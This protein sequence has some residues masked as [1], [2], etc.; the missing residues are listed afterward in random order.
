MEADAADRRHTWW[1]DPE[2]HRPRLRELPAEPAA[3]AD[4]IEEFVIHHAVARL[5]GFGV[6]VAAERDRELRRAS[7]LLDEALCRDSRPLTEHRAIA[8]YVYVTC[9]DFA[10]LAASAL[11]E[12][13]VPARLRAGF[14]SYFRPGYWEDHWV[15]EHRSGDAWMVLDAQL[16]PRA[17]EGLRIAF[18]VAD[19]P[20]SG[21][22]S[23]ASIWRTVRSGA[24]D[25]GVCGLSYAGIAGEWWIAASVIR[26]AAALA[27]IEGLPWDRW[28][29]GCALHDTRN[30]TPEQARDIDALA[31]ALE[32]APGDRRDAEAVLARFPWA[33][34]TRT[35]LSFLEGRQSPEA[36]SPGT[37]SLADL[38][39]P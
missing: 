5:L 35:V 27:G 34:P 36:C 29:P 8:D 25:P 13:G 14:A 32:P 2:A 30:V 20:A 16:G 9:R 37:E 26:D 1:S 7:R 31:Q 23:A 28:G 22:R 19:V 10:L 21:W 17:R 11:R 12:R 18:D 33:S 39:A 3:I 24:V 38:Q 15:C 6:P 4:G